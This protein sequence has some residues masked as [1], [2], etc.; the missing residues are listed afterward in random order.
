MNEQK[1]YRSTDNEPFV[2]T[3]TVDLSIS[4][5]PGHLVGTKYGF[6]LKTF[7]D[8]FSF[9]AY[10]INLNM[11][12]AA[13][14]RSPSMIKRKLSGYNCCGEDYA[15]EISQHITLI[16]F[17]GLGALHLQSMDR[18]FHTD[19]AMHILKL[20]DELSGV[21]LSDEIVMG[22]CISTLYLFFS[23][24]FQNAKVLSQ[25]LHICSTIPKQEL[26]KMKVQTQQVSSFI[27]FTCFLLLRWDEVS[28]CVQL[29][30]CEVLEP[31]AEFVLRFPVMSSVMTDNSETICSSEVM[32]LVQS[33]FEKGS[34]LGDM[35]S[36]SVSL[37]WPI[38]LK[39][40]L[41]SPLV[42][43]S[44]RV[45]GLAE[46]SSIIS[47][48]MQLL[49]EKSE[50]IFTLY[51][52]IS[53]VF[54]EILQQNHLQAEES[55]R[56]LILFLEEDWLVLRAFCLYPKLTHILHMLC[57]AFSKLEMHADYSK[58]LRVLKSASQHFDSLNFPECCP[59]SWHGLCDDDDCESVWKLLDSWNSNDQRDKLKK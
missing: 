40:A 44:R 38:L 12:Q 8:R 28:K 18:K 15:T 51:W 55:L 37:C 20:L 32:S 39:K 48:T 6:F 54:G 59:L 1:T 45:E 13:L 10:L 30:L 5:I 46:L 36:F 25:M 33:F 23:P 58:F 29:K 14:I 34:A 47:H 52:H 19:L 11:L 7:V 31:G 26:S 2:P 17:V 22:R 56:Q 43:D 53:L 49:F 4:I 16:S 27:S 50:P 9:F 41:L 3:P 42:L 35:F 57:S 21:M 24:H